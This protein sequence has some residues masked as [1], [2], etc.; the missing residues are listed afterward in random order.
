MALADT[1]NSTFVRR[2]TVFLGTIFIGA[3]AT[4]MY[5]PRTCA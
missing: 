1:T 4:E 3:F 5:E 2:N